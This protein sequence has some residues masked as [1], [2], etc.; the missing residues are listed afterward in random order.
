MIKKTLKIIG[1]LALVIILLVTV[2][3]VLG[4]VLRDE[5]LL[6]PWGTAFFIMASGSMEPV[7]PTGSIVLVTSVAPEEVIVGDMITYFVADKTTVVTHGVVEISVEDGNYIYTTRGYANDRN[8][9]PFGY[10]MVIGRVSYVIPGSSF[11]IRLVGNAKYAGIAVI[12]VGLALCVLSFI[13]GSKKREEIVTGSSD[14][15]DSVESNFI[16][17]PSEIMDEVQ[18][19]VDQYKYDVDSDRDLKEVTKVDSDGGF[20]SYGEDE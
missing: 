2:M 10:D 9:S 13:K 20:G 8:D 1:I 6:S 16:S 12:V 4:A 17:N 7:L 5:K 15:I 14:N 19:E 18:K 3:V 11:L